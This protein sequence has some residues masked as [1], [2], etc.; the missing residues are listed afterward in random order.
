M[1]R[2]TVVGHSNSKTQEPQIVKK[3]P[4]PNFLRDI[5]KSTSAR[6]SAVQ[7]IEVPTVK[8]N[9]N[10]SQN[11]TKVSFSTQ[12]N[13]EENKKETGKPKSVLKSA[14]KRT[15]HEIPIQKSAVLYDAHD[16][17]DVI[18]LMQEKNTTKKNKNEN[19][20]ENKKVIEKNNLKNST[21]LHSDSKKAII[22]QETAKKSTM[23]GFFA[24]GAMPDFRSAVNKA[25]KRKQPIAND[26]GTKKQKGNDST[27]IEQKVE[28]KK[29]DRKM[30]SNKEDQNTGKKAS[31]MS[32][33][34]M[35]DF[36]EQDSDDGD[37]GDDGDDDNYMSN[38]FNDSDDSSGPEL[39]MNFDSDEDEKKKKKL[40][41]NSQNVKD[42]K[43]GQKLANSKVQLAPIEKKSAKIQQQSEEEEG[44][45]DGFLSDDDELKKSSKKVVIPSR[46]DKNKK[47]KQISDEEVEMDGFLSSED[48]SKKKFKKAL[49]RQVSDDD[50]D[51]DDD[52]ND[53]HSGNTKVLF[54]PKTPS[55][56]QI[57]STRPPQ[58]EIKNNLIPFFLQNDTIKPTSIISLTLYSPLSTNKKSQQKQIEVSCY[59]LPTYQNQVHSIISYPYLNTLNDALYYTMQSEIHSRFLYP[60]LP[61]PIVPKHNLTSPSSSLHNAS[62][63]HLLLI[64]NE[65]MIRHQQSSGLFGKFNST[66]SSL[67]D[68]TFNN[69]EQWVIRNISVDPALL[70]SSLTSFQHRK[71][72]FDSLAQ[73]K[74]KSQKFVSPTVLN[75]FTL[76]TPTSRSMQSDKDKESDIL[77]GSVQQTLHDGELLSALRLRKLSDVEV[78][79]QLTRFSKAV[80]GSIDEI[81]S[82]QAILHN[83]GC[84]PKDT[85]IKV[86]EDIQKGIMNQD[87]TVLYNFIKEF[88]KISVTFHTSIGPISLSIP[89]TVK[90]IIMY[91]SSMILNHCFDD[92]I[93][94]NL[95]NL[96]DLN[97]LI[98]FDSKR[99]EKE[100]D[101]KLL[102]SIIKTT[103]PHLGSN[104]T[105]AKGDN[106]DKKGNNIV[107]IDGELFQMDD[108][109]D[110]QKIKP[111]STISP[112]LTL[113]VAHILNRLQDKLPSQS[114]LYQYI[115]MLLTGLVVVPKIPNLKNP[116]TSL[117]QF[118]QPLAQ[119]IVAVLFRYDSLH[120]CQA[121]SGGGNQAAVPTKFLQSC[122]EVFGTNIEAFASPLNAYYNTYC[123]AFSDTDAPFG[124]LGSFF[125]FSPRSGSIFVNPPFAANTILAS[126]IHAEQLLAISD[127]NCNNIDDDKNDFDN[128]VQNELHFDNGLMF[129]FVFPYKHDELY[130]QWITS[131]PYCQS[132][133]I[134]PARQH[135][136]TLGRQETNVNK[137]DFYRPARH[138]SI[139]AILQN[140]KATR[141]KPVTDEKM[142]ELLKYFLVSIPRREND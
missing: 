140:K 131:S 25:Q 2:F 132:F 68:N 100:H 49:K 30:E 6:T 39:D 19:K 71:I 21:K 117:P 94:T 126:I 56:Q 97:S 133:T 91:I 134:L 9:H 48:D 114:I 53:D 63:H 59:D 45:L 118:P 96:S 137:K 31:F 43:V 122:G 52:D 29:G 60:Y 109:N 35:M 84:H 78:Q 90:L 47:S 82:A 37:D 11:V 67:K 62:N 93:M 104:F 50:D 139:L 81:K 13:D 36:Y 135:V 66:F 40:S 108:H 141:N 123:S 130:T 112:K 136:Y 124:S 54:G 64:L 65:E 34:D 106:N 99:E 17:D 38:L 115:S 23:P 87:I 113:Q 22:T 105:P 41:K 18:D 89:H 121:K 107:E 16:D 42:N 142:A 74:F 69:Y 24:A 55:T 83:K 3:T 120:G 101:Y 125:H 85:I 72:L 20:N 61:T 129:I 119:A 46:M 70:P 32:V 15:I 110:A 51:D 95:M 128:P 26:V 103:L 14:L 73:N 86:S 77:F 102:E 12:T 10:T 79:K 4:A 58:K 75:K 76:H 92:K 27:V 7:R 28:S 44:E 127:R 138:D 80:K 111:T 33:G 1:S 116:T 98:G 88:N 8:I 5:I 57:S